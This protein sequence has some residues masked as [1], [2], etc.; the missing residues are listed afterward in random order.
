MQILLQI[1]PVAIVPISL[2]CLDSFD[3]EQM[4]LWNEILQKH[5]I[6]LQESNGKI[7][8]VGQ[9]FALYQAQKAFVQ[10]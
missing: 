9:I 7:F 3:G 6:T 5:E 2:K 1:F 4:A 8:A 10:V